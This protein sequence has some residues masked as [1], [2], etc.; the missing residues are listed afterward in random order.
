[1]LADAGSRLA[2]VDAR[3]AGALSAIPGLETMQ[4]AEA[5]G[6]Q[7]E[8]ARVPAIG[9]DDLAYILY[10]S[11]STGQP[12]GVPIRHGSLSNFLQSMAARPGLS[13]GDRLL[14]VTTIAFD[15]AG[16]ELFGPLTQGGTL[17]LTDAATARDGVRLAA[18]L[19]RSQATVMQATPAGWRL[20][21]EAGWQGRR[22][23]K[24]LCGGEALDSRLAGDLLARGDAVWN[25]Y[26]P[27]ET[28][29]WS[30]ALRVEP[31]LPGDATVPV[32]GSLDHT[33]LYVLDPRGMPVP[34]GVPGELHIGGAGLSPGYWR[35][36]GLTADRFIP[37]ALGVG[38]RLYR[39]G[40]RVR[41][42]ED[43]A[44]EFLGRL[45]GQIKLRGHRIELGEIEAR[46]ASHAAVAQAVAVVADDGTGP[47]LV[48]F[49]RWE[50][51]APAEGTDALAEH[52]A[53][54]L[55]AYMMPGAY[56][57]LADIP[58]T[59]NG[60]IDRRALQVLF[61]ESRAERISRA[62]LSA[63][64]APAY[65]EPMATI[66]AIWRD[67]LR[68]ERVAPGDNFFD[69]GG[70]SLLVVTVQSAI[71]R[72]LDAAI[73]MVDIF[74]FPTLQ[75]LSDHVAALGRDAEA[76]ATTDRGEARVQGQERLRQSRQR[77]HG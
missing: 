10:T 55:P 38:A 24:I 15:I 64:A 75:T 57:P 13:A 41:W 48:A 3:G 72:R 35:K 51:E 8:P 49:V 31:A 20:L 11:G 29:I 26:G 53:A 76:S 66:A 5:I 61:A 28:T 65:G 17:I 67:A 1:M 7:V 40:D 9:A 73:E 43:G 39:T 68:I 19:E 71:A 42:R 21:V 54:A 16:L 45:D 30:A 23:L 62:D 47:R 74:R 77:R 4:V 18:L 12:K 2:L 58:L 6:A 27:T 36:P 63:G 70:H 46:L 32:G 14:A 52:L 34:V 25:L 33:Q 50:G 59:P 69:L 56:I 22:G 44:L 60:K 37:D